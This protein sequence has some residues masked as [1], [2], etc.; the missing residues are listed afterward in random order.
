[1]A[2]FPHQDAT[3]LYTEPLGRVLGVWI[4]LEDA[5]LENGCLWFIPGSHTSEDTCFSLPTYTPPA[6]G[7][8]PRKKERL[9]A[10]PWPAG[11]VSR[12]MVRAPAGSA[13]GTSFLGSEP[14][15]DNSL[16]VP[17]P[18]QRGRWGVEGRILWPCPWIS[19]RSDH[20]A[21]LRAVKS[22][23]ERQSRDMGTLGSSGIQSKV[24]QSGYTPTR[25]LL[26]SLGK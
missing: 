14:A 24:S 7:E 15:W 9:N 25:L 21:H 10:L 20:P 8:E 23:D 5:T 4:A 17:T 2:V 6:M 1:M 13:P 12:R 18:V 26:G 3:F 11:G 22:Q 19:A 16:F